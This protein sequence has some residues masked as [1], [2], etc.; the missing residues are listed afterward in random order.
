MLQLIINFIMAHSSIV[1]T[2]GV[3]IL[4]LIFAINPSAESNG[5]LHWLFVQLGVLKGSS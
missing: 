2:L 1:G 5:I 4:D 3:A